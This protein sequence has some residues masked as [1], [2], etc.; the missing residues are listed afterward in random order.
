M[1]DI[2]KGYV[3][4]VQKKEDLG[5]DV[6]K[7]GLSNQADISR[8]KSYGSKTI[9]FRVYACPITPREIEKDLLKEFNKKFERIGGPL[10]ESFQGDV[11]EMMKLF[12]SITQKYQ[13]SIDKKSEDKKNKDGDVTFAIFGANVNFRYYLDNKIHAFSEKTNGEIL[14][15]VRNKIIKQNVWHNLYDEN[16]IE[17]VNKAKIQLSLIATQRFPLEKKSN[18]V[19]L[20]KRY[21]LCDVILFD[22]LNNNEKI[23]C[24]HVT[25]KNAVTYVFE[26]DDGFVIKCCRFKNFYIRVTMLDFVFP[27]SIYS[28]TVTKKAYFSMDDNKCYNHDISHMDNFVAEQLYDNSTAPWINDNWA[29]VYF[30]LLWKYSNYEIVNKNCT[31]IPRLSEKFYNYVLP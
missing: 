15:M 16:F 28:N 24:F 1:T 23:Y 22:V 4:L 11:K 26:Y 6:Y 21:F 27:I 3:Y 17:K 30:A 25:S 31:F 10:C 12:D 19:S 13:F 14:Y 2:Y 18:I 5:T 9:V 20:I 7:I 29:D 8:V